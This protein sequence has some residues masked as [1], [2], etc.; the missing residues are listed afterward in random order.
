MEKG[1]SPDRPVDPYDE[2]IQALSHKVRNRKKK[3]EKIKK[4]KADSK[5]KLITLTKEQEEIIGS[6]EIVVLQLKEFEE[7]LKSFQAAQKKAQA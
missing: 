5:A 7:V 4:L 2:S 1:D 3:L 6:E